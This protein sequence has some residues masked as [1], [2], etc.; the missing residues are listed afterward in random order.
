[1]GVK[2]NNDSHCSLS[3][4]MFNL[5]SEGGFRS[6]S[7]CGGRGCDKQRKKLFQAGPPAY[8]KAGAERG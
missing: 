3:E 6:K 2:R 1:M 4:K 7:A 5:K 8:V